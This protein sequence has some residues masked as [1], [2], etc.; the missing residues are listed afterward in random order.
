MKQ[1]IRDAVYQALTCL[2]LDIDMSNFNRERINVER[3]RNP[4]HGDFACNIAMMLAKQAKTNPRELATTIIAN[5]PSSSEI[6]EISIAGPGFIN[7]RLT[8]TALLPV[9]TDILSQANRYGDND[10]GKGKRVHIEFVSAN[11]TGPLHV[12]H[13][14]GAAYGA[15]VANL[16]SH[17]GFDVHREYYVNDAGR[18][19]RI[20]ALSVWIRYLQ[21]FKEPIELPKNA[22]QG[23]YIRD[24]AEQLNQQ[25]QNRFHHNAAQILEQLP[26]DIDPVEDKESYIDAFVSVAKQM[27]GEENF[28]IIHD[29]G[30]SS[31]LADIEDDLGEFGIT[32]QEWFRESKLFDMGWLNEGVDLL[33]QHGYTYEQDN[34]LWFRAT[35]LGDEK[36]R[37]LIRS[38]GQPTY[39]ASDVAYHLYKYN[40]GYDHII[41]V[42][43]ADHHGYISRIRSFLKGLG[44]DPDKLTILLVQFAILYRG[45]EK[46]SMSTRSG[47]FVT[48]RELRYEVGNDAARYFYIMRKPEQH[49]DF[50]LDLAKSQSNDNPV[51]YVQYAHARVCSVWRQLDSNSLEYDQ[52]IGIENLSALSLAHEKQLIATLAHYAEIIHNAAINYEPHLLANYLQELAAQFHSYYNACKFIVDDQALR[53]ARLCLIAA[54]RQV[55]ANGLHILGLSAPETM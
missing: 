15:C 19:M 26:T 36:D 42:F 1:L 53:N 52:N 55:I 34:T 46:V 35:E 7:F 51:F 37:V 47:E 39:F 4:E 21:F 6:A 41:D 48:L 29:Q 18:Q 33:K 25:Y 49:L 28:A 12:G 11:P 30:L 9:I 8:D 14:R 54:V 2:E 24:I 17:V 3:C 10:Y 16:L 44:K 13:G 20:L 45:K 5:I 32:Y 38:N 27:L 23:N 31:I 22:Y 50:D 40:Q 43:G